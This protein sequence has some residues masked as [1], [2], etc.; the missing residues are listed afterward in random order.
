MTTDV[1]PRQTT[2]VSLVLMQTVTS[3]TPTGEPWVGG[4]LSGTG[5]A[6]A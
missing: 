2:L 4:R 5:A 3:H 1:R 6:F